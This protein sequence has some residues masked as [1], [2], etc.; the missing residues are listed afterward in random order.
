MPQTAIDLAHLARQT[1]GDHALERELLALFAQQCVR[2]LRTIHAGADAQT[3]MDAA[4]TLKG[5][6]RAIGA[7]QV[8][9]AADAIEQHLAEPDS[10]RT[11]TAMDALA[12]AAAEARAAISRLDC[13]A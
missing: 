3:R 4:H 13:A 12:L 2:H 1:G 8:A 7:W 11:E 5:A 10:R 9:D 6:A